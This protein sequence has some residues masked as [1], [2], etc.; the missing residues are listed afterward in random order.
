MQRGL[1]AE[2]LSMCGYVSVVDHEF[3]SE[4]VETIRSKIPAIPAQTID[5]NL[6]A[7]SMDVI[8][9]V[10]KRVRREIQTRLESCV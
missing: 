1:Q 8:W 2:P 5:T 9:P 3:D 10:S 6:S 4:L 7:N